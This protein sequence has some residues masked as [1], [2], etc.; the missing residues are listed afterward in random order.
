[1]PKALT[2]VYFFNFCI[3]VVGAVLRDMMKPFNDDDDNECDDDLLNIKT[4]MMIASD[5]CDN[6]YGIDDNLYNR[7][8]LSS[9]PG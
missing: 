5:D 8:R 6:E 2:Q 1:M 3:Y 9:H 4:M 7:H